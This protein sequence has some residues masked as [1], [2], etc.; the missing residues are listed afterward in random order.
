[1]GLFNK[2]KKLK[3]Y[4]R[5]RKVGKRMNMELIEKLP[6]KAIVDC[7]KKFRMLKRNT[8]MLENENEL[9]ILFD[10]CIHNCRQ[11]GKNVVEQ[12]IDNS[13]PPPIS[14]EM[15]LLR[16]MSK[17]YYS[18]FQVKQVQKGEGATLLDIIR[19]TS[20]FLMDI[21]IAGSAR[22]DMIFAGRVMNIGDFY[23]TTG[24]FIA[25]NIEILEGSIMPIVK[26]FFKDKNPGT[27][28]PPLRES[29]FSA[30][31]IRASLK[32]GALDYMKYDN[33]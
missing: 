2:S 7:A 22:E 19:D 9:S 27:I 24:S 13:A 29:K 28:L 20:L 32:A 10:Y 1:M 23:M 6:K 5:L 17:S 18:L 33:V 25:L 11:K 16:A 4:K 12:Y 14:D 15:I 8:L 3:R 31:I 26:K 21:G 30:E